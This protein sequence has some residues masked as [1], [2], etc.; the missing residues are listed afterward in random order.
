MEHRNSTSLTTTRPLSGTMRGHLGT[1]SHEFFHVWNVERIRP[2]SLEPFDF[3]R[4]NMS[5]ELWFAEGFTN[6]YGTLL[7]RRAGFLTDEEYAAALAGPVR[8]LLQAPGRRFFSAVDMSRQA[9]FSDQAVSIDVWNSANTFISYYTYGEALGIALDLTIRSR[10]PGVS[11]DDF[12]K[13]MWERHGRTEVPYTLDDLRRT[14]GAVTR[15]QAFADDFFR[16]Y[17]TGRDVP[18]Y[19]AL[20]ATVGLVLRPSRPNTAWM[21]EAFTE[22]ADRAGLVLGNTRADEPRYAAGLAL[23]DTLLTVEG[24]PIP[25]RA[26]LDSILGARRPGDT[27][28]VTYGGRGARGAGRVVL[29]RHPA[30]EVLPA[31]A[32]G[33]SIDASALEARRRWLASRAG[34]QGAPR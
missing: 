15:D 33:L 10:F 25:T 22:S 7:L 8:T 30:L 32:A 11:L 26:V 20:L 24:Q 5:G 23:G 18:D 9:P 6:Y 34:T 28:A 19:G 13:A 17:I 29:A 2:R 31:E 14:L 3:T 12:M 16:R 4:A 21:G 1:V 27:L